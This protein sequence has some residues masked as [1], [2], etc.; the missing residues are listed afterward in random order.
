VSTAP[1]PE[2]LAATLAVVELETRS[3]TWQLA[4]GSHGQVSAIV[5]ISEA[6]PRSA[7]PGGAYA[8]ER[9]KSTVSRGGV[10]ERRLV[11]AS[12]LRARSS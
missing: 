12:G 8:D 9:W 4:D 3:V 1:P 7:D 5:D 10:N 2:A 6:S 11:G